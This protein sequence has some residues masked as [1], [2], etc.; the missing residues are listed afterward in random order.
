MRPLSG[1]AGNDAL[2]YALHVLLT[3]P[4]LVNYLRSSCLEEDLNRKR[5]NAVGFA[6]GLARVADEYWNDG[7]DG[8]VDAAEPLAAFRRI[9]RATHISAP[10]AVRLMFQSLQDAVP[11]PGNLLTELGAPWLSLGPDSS[12]ESVQQLLNSAPPP[13]PPVLIFVRLDRGERVRRF[14]NYGTVLKQ[15]QVKSNK[16][17]TSVYE[18]FSVLMEG[19]GDCRVYARKAALWADASGDKVVPLVDINRLISYRAQVLV[20]LLRA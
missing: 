6:Q 16:V 7:A 20:Y 12:C 2:V 3:I 5:V 17:H 10:T 15:I 4:P 11:T 19:D 9:H 18:L 8:P 1:G 13:D 14:V